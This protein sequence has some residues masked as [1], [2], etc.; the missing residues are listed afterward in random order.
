MKTLYLNK[1]LKVCA[2]EEAT[3]KSEISDSQILECY[4]HE[5]SEAAKELYTT[6]NHEPLGIST[7]NEKKKIGNYEF[8]W[9]TEK[10]SANED[11]DPLSNI[12]T[13]KKEPRWIVE[14]GD[15]EVRFGTECSQN[16]AV[17]WLNAFEKIS[18]KLLDTTLTEGSLV[19]EVGMPACEL[20]RPCVG[21]ACEN[22]VMFPLGSNN[23]NII[24]VWVEKAAQNLNL[25]PAEIGQITLEKMILHEI[26]HTLKRDPVLHKLREKLNE[27]IFTGFEDLEEIL[28][29]IS[30]HHLS[31]R[32]YSQ[33][34]ELQAANKSYEIGETET[35]KDRYNASGEVF[36]EVIRH[37]YLEPHLTKLAKRPP[38]KETILTPI[39]NFLIETLHTE[40][41]YF[42]KSKEPEPPQIL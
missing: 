8:R 28:E 36:A 22:H 4:N 14:I 1:S 13:R 41:I 5:L 38:K 18:R 12:G 7:P 39:L 2:E 6:L 9:D 33:K 25:H 30:P 40:K 31:K 21:M 15:T 23:R 42:P 27:D 16:D 24:A 20:A 35:K 11:L 10:F 17:A 37:Y 29:E 34:K 3:F 26:G 19:F 32:F